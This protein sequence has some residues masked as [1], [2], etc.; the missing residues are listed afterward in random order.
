M[1][2]TCLICSKVFFKKENESKKYWQTKRYCSKLCSDSLSLWQKGK[3]PW[4]KGKKHLAITGNK[5]PAWK[6]GVTP[7]NEIARKSN[8]YKLWQKTIFIKDN[9]TC[10]TCFKRGGNLNAHHI[11]PF[12]IYIDLRFALD[13]GITLCEECHKRVNHSELLNNNY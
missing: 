13:N 8:L 12:A 10:Q 9:Y 5:N 7:E 6:G 1:N 3:V 4:N 2:K 11:K